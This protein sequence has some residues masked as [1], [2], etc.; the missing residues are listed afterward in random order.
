MKR[1]PR[2]MRGARLAVSGVLDPQP[3]AFS[4]LTS[5]MKAGSTFR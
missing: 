3:W 4:F 5:S 1:A 2:Q